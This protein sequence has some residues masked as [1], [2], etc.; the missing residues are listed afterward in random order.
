MSPVDSTIVSGTRERVFR[1][2]FE[3]QP[4]SVRLLRHALGQYLTAIGVDE[5]AASRLQLCADEA[6]ANSIAHAPR[7]PVVIAAWV[8]D[9]RLVLEV[10]DG[11]PGFDVGMARRDELPDLDAEHGRGLFLIRGLMDRVDIDSDEQGT[12][13]RMESQLPPTVMPLAA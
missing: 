4:L 6:L 12:T 10:S 11:G 3:P 7:S 2:S 8:R 9:D 5:V 1:R 13:I